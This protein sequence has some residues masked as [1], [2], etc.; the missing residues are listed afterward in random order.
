MEPVKE[1]T[2]RKSVR[3]LA[4]C[5]VFVALYIIGAYIRIPFPIVPMTLQTLFVL[6]AAMLLG[7]LPAAGS[8]AVYLMLGLSGIPV[9]TSGGG[10]FYIFSP[11]FGYL[12][13]FIPA[14]LVTGWLSGTSRE[15]RF[16]RYWLSGLAGI[17]V[18]YSFGIAYLFLL[19][20]SGRSTAPDTAKIFSL[21]FMITAAGDVLKTAAAAVSTVKLKRS[22]TSFH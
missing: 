18:I 22:M 3:I 15:T 21:G 14:A 4:L 16:L 19:S 17:I 20:A 5:S 12:L 11:T 1:K 13:G 8:V 7:P 6:T 2:R 10:I 9:F